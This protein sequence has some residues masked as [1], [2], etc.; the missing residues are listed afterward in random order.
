MRDPTTSEGI[1]RRTFVTGVAAGSLAVAGCTNEGSEGDDASEGG[2]GDEGEDADFEVGP[3]FREVDDPPDAVYLPTHREAMRTVDPLEAGDYILVPMLSYPHPFWLVTGGTGEDDVSREVPDDGRGV[4]LMFVLRDAKTDIVLPV[5]DGAR[6]EIFAD[7]EPVDGPRSPWPMISQE[8]GFHFGDN[9]SLPG[10]GTYRV[11]ITLAPLSARTTG[12]LEGRFGERATASFE[13]VYDDAFREA[14]V[15]GVDYL[16]EEEWGRRD[17]LEPMG[18]AVAG[19]PTI[20]DYPGRPLVAPDGGSEDGAGPP[21]S[22][23]AAVL[24]TLVESGNRFAADDPYLLVSL[25]TPY[26]GVPLPHASPSATVERDGDPI[27]S[28]VPLEGAVDGEVGHHYGAS[29]ADVRPG[30]AV[31]IA[32][33]SPPQVA[34]HQGYETAF[35]EMPP[36]ELEVTDR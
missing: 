24:G 35:L 2:D 5:E 12:D 17:A 27:A 33:E 29:L 1:D 3:A 13:F 11:E 6:I 26:N 10:D 21:R 22:G 7:G 23:D 34:R 18:N 20:A 16:E 36:V 15:G 30:D 8:M 4:H 19:G 14:V 32:F 25:R 31:T 9:V 28:E